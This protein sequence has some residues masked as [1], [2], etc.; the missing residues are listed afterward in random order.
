MMKSVGQSSTENKCVCVSAKRGK[1]V[2]QDTQK[3][4]LRLDILRG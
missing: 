2:L 3:L 1:D 4:K